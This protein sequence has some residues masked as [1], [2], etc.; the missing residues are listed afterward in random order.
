[1]WFEQLMGFAENTTDI[2]RQRS[3]VERLLHNNVTGKILYCGQF[4]I[5][6]FAEFQS[7]AR[8]VSLAK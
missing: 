2:Y 6:T 4:T 8:H 7:E 5:S 1:M 3:D